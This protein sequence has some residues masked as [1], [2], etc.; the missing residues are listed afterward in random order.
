M[1][2]GFEGVGEKAGINDVIFSVIK[3]NSFNGYCLRTTTIP[4]SYSLIVTRPGLC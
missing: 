1:V 3:N 4:S 2:A